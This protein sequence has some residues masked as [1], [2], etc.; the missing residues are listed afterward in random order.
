MGYDPATG[1]RLQRTKGG[2]PTKKIAE[3][4]ARDAIT[5]A[6]QPGGLAKGDQRLGVYLEGWLKSVESDL[7]ATTFASYGNAVKR[8]TAELVPSD[9]AISPPR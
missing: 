8:L 6:S 3:A 2:F 1:K 5:E 9:C 4:A 7:R